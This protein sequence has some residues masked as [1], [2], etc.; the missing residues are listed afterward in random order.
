M[1]EFALAL[2]AWVAVA[3]LW[4]AVVTYRQDRGLDTPRAV[5]EIGTP[6][7]AEGENA[8]VHRAR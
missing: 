5:N 7:K 4:A 2:A 3:A 8:R 1:I 6:T